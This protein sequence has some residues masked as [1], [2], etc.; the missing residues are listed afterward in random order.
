MRMEPP[1]SLSSLFRY[2]FA[3]FQYGDS[4]PLEP[5]R[6]AASVYLHSHHLDFDLHPGPVA[7]A[8]SDAKNLHKSLMIYIFCPENPLCSATDRLLRIPAIGQAISA[9]YVFYATSSTTSDG[10]SILTGIRFRSLPLILLVR[11]SGNSLQES[12]VFVTHQGDISESSLLSYFA[13]DHRPPADPVRAEQDREFQEAI[14]EVEQQEVIQHEAV[15]RYESERDRIAAE[16]AALPELPHGAPNVCRV[17]FQMPDN[18]NPEKAFPKDGPI[19]MLFVFARHLLF[20][21]KFA[22]FTGFPMS[23]IEESQ[24][25]IESVCPYQQFLVRVQY[26]D[27]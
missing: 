24:A 2:L 5:P 27:E 4:V 16:F 6:H 23:R 26:D 25:T 21:K 1:F 10:Y 22:L 15:G 12:T 19:S 9:N 8:I 13:M 20:P 3:R 18:S 7:T 17:R 11:P 14:L